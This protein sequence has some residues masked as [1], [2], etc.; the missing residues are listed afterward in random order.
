MTL[1]LHVKGYMMN[2]R[3]VATVAILAVMATSGGCSGMRNFLFGRGAACGPGPAAAVPMYGLPGIE[4]GC[5]M[6][7]GCGFEPGCGYEL[8]CGYEPGCG[9]EATPRHRPFAGLRGGCGLLRGHGSCAGS[10]ACGCGHHGSYMPGQYDAYSG[11]VHD[12][13]SYGGAAI[14][15]QIVGDS[16]GGYPST[17]QPGMLFPGSGSMGDNFNLRGETIIDGSMLPGT[18]VRP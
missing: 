9:Y 16:F 4:R 5:G 2:I 15:S 6:E 8:G 7:R 10:A 17:I 11:A 3:I 13:Y 14:G 18:V 1:A 12:P